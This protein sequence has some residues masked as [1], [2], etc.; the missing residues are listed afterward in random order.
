MPRPR[1]S[2][3]KELSLVVKDLIEQGQSI[4]DI[5]IILGCLGKDAKKWLADLK[6]ECTTIDEFLEIASKRADIALVAA[7]VEAATGYD[8]EEK[9]TEYIKVM[10]GYEANDKAKPVLADVEKG[11]KIKRRHA[12]KNDTLLKFIL[13]NRLPEYFQDVSKVEVNKKTIEI[14]Q[15]TEDEIKSFAGRLLETIQENNDR[16]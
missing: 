10:K 16:P 6:K 5:G 2:L 9:D 13:K 7:A 11:H 1:K 8:Y 3:N 14:K 4:A 12:K 15:I